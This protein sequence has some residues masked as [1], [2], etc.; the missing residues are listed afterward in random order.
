MPLIMKLDQ[1]FQNTW[2]YSMLATHPRSISNL[3]FIFKI[4]ILSAVLQA[5]SIHSSY[6]RDVCDK[7]EVEITTTPAPI[8]R[9]ASLSRYEA[10]KQKFPQ[11]ANVV[12]FGDSLAE[13]WPQGN[14]AA[15][16][17]G[18]TIANLGVGGDVTQWALGR[19]ESSLMQKLSPE[20]VL[21]FL[22]TNNLRATSAC[23]I[24]AGITAA[25]D[26]LHA[27]WPNAIIYSMT[28]APRGPLFQDSES[29]RIAINAALKELPSKYSFLKVVSGYD[30][31]ITCNTRQLSITQQ[32]LPSFFP[33]S[34][35]NYR[36]DNLHLTDQG[37]AVL[38]DY[39][40]RVM[41]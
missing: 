6:A 36:P 34:C 19:L 15:L 27:L 26:R 9:A 10:I 20:I 35:A 21:L 31:V 8:Q 38:G 17:P 1:I 41:Q 11:S 28:I 40:K 37:Y 4:V 18:K 29:D 12:V 14:L 16:F 23:S 5:I 3:S 25:I 39:L 24:A 2:S 30:D 32:I 33:D 7:Y 22:G 13:R